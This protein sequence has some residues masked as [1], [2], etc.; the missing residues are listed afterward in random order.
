MQHW[1]ENNKSEKMLELGWELPS[2]QTIP[3]CWTLIST[4]SLLL[5]RKS[6]LCAIVVQLSS[7]RLRPGVKPSL[8][9]N[10]C[11]PGALFCICSGTVGLL[12]GNALTMLVMTWELSSVVLSG[13]LIAGIG[14]NVDFCRHYV[15]SIVI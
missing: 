7:V 13:L 15:N 1:W 8:L 12:F 6:Q 11:G 14:F 2:V 10:L 5:T 4:A 9:I 3:G